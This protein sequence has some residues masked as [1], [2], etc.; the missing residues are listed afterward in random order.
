MV[1]LPPKLSGKAAKAHKSGHQGVG[2][3]HDD[4]QREI[5]FKIKY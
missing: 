2:A 1:E 3:D 4:G 5:D